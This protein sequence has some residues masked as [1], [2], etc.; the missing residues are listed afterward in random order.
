MSHR[1]QDKVILVTGAAQGIG[2]ACARQAAAEGA[3]V[4]LADIQ[5]DRGEKAA[6]TLRNEG[7]HAQ[8]HAVDLREESQVAALFDHAI[9]THK[10]L[11][12][13]VNNAGWFPR[14]T[15]EQTTT[16]LWEEVLNVNLRSAFYCCKYA[17][18]HMR[19]TRAGSIVNM[20]SI[21]GIQSLP[22]LVAYGAAK[23]GLLTLTRT[24]AGALAP[25]RIRVNYVIPGWVFTEG[26]L[27]I[28]KGE[29]RT[30]DDL[31]QAGEKLA[32]GRAQ[33]PQETA[34][35]VV[36]L[37]SDESAQVTGTTLHLDAGASTLPIQPGTYPG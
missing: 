29:G 27:A 13:L 25:H 37:L 12:G 30:E 26:E 3:S 23:G 6:T 21:C 24:L 9:R 35:A 31:R 19:A 18:P 14:A 1:L 28:Q 10:K 17:V 5:Q 22:N 16:Q 34:Y 20:G 11:D 7:H 8:F 36:Y 32:F 2:F 33:T 4:L 15:L